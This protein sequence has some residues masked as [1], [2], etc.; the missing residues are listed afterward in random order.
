MNNIKHFTESLKEFPKQRQ[1][2]PGL[3]K[4]MVPVPDCG[5]ESYH[6][7]NQLCGKKMLVTG[8]DSGIGRAVAIAYAKEGAK[9]VVNYLPSEEEDALEMKAS[10]KELKDNVIL[11]PGDLREESFCKKLVKEAYNQLQGLDNITL[12][13]GYQQYQYRIED[14]ST[15]Q[16]DNTF[17]INV[18]SMFWIIREALTYLSESGSII[19]TTS[20]QADKPSSHLLDY[21][22]TKGAIKTFTR[23]LALQLANK[24][25]RVNSVAP[26]PIWTVLQ[27]AG[28]QPQDNLPTFG[29]NTPLER[30]GEPYEVAGV[31]VFLASDK[32]SYIT[33]EIVK[34][35]GGEW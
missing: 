21:A 3:Q 13:A 30:P 9:V 1:S 26:G 32:A 17:K 31:Y 10:L 20:I 24:N 29:Q 6:A 19:T 35:T 18:Y 23:G 2:P 4:K 15:E 27:V 14:I 25:I 12:V 16:L 34:V 8:G 33:G 22:T 11:I 5:E 7:C 28:G